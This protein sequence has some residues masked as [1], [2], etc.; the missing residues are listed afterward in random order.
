[1]GRQ[2]AYYDV[3]QICSNGHVAN[4]SSRELPQHNQK[5]CAQCGALTITTCPSCE[6][7]IRGYLWNTG[8]FPGPTYK[9]PACCH[10]CGMPYPWTQ[11][12]LQAATKSLQLL[13]PGMINGEATADALQDVVLNRPNASASAVLLRSV[14]EGADPMLID[15][16]KKTVE[17]I[18]PRELQQAMWPDTPKNYWGMND[19]EL[20]AKA[21]KYGI[22]GYGGDFG[23]IDRQMIVSALLQKDATLHPRSNVNLHFENSTISGINFG[24]I[25]R[26]MKTTMTVLQKSGGGHL[27]EALSKIADAIAAS[28]GLDEDVK[29]AAIEALDLLGGEGEKPEQQRK[30]GATRILYDSLLRVVGNA[31]D[32][33][34]I[35]TWAY[36]TLAKHFGW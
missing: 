28:R 6:T 31:S 18:V 22:R 10:E 34:T 21:Q 36:P 30:P 1:M 4:S 23:A 15:I 7:P 3:A 5:H 16:L 2:E 12:K 9:A 19:E 11:S 32:V 29:K 13:K 17:D 27:A 33:I 26:D 24:D 35:C 25:R 20:E 8:V 14:L